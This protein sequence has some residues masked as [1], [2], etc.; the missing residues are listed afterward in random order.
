MQNHWVGDKVSVILLCHLSGQAISELSS[1]H[2]LN[3]QVHA[4]MGPIQ[5]YA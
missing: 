1:D 2:P 5:K 3:H 4:C